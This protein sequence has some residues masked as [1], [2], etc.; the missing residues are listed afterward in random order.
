MIYKG[1]FFLLISTTY[2]YGMNIT[3][4]STVNNTQSKKAS[5]S[6]THKKTHSGYFDELPLEVQGK[7]VKNIFNLVIH[8]DDQSKKYS[9]HVILERYGLAIPILLG[10]KFSYEFFQLQR[11]C[12]WKIGGK[13][14]VAQELFVL[15]H[16]EKA[17]FERMAK[18]PFLASGNIMPGDYAIIKEMNNED[19]KKGLDLRVNYNNETLDCMSNCGFFGVMLSCI[20]SVC[21]MP[22]CAA[23]TGCLIGAIIS[24]GIF[25]GAEVGMFF[26]NGKHSNCTGIKKAKF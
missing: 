17:V 15:S 18:H 12:K 1:F 16:E 19:I 7:I 3:T 25:C 21:V 20:G 11:N 2:V 14:F 6:K 13:K 8:K 22:Y 10:L 26:V 23:K 4:L 9:D 24:S 5:L